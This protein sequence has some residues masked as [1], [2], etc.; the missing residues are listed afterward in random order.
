MSMVSMKVDVTITDEDMDR[1]T[2]YSLKDAYKFNAGYNT[3]DNSE[4][5]IEPDYAFLRSVDHVLEYFLNHNQRMI[6]EIEKRAIHEQE[7][8]NP[9]HVE[10]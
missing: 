8:T 2:I 10:D 5:R 4:E 9:P 1:I 7:G 3:I 6:W